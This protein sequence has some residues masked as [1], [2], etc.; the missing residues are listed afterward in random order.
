MNYKFHV[1]ALGPLLSYFYSV[2]GESK[3][4][5]MQ[6]VTFIGKFGIS[7]TFTLVFVYTTEVYP[8][9]FR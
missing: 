3:V 7:A 9:N 5:A 2:A 4:I 1:Q 6:A 8:T